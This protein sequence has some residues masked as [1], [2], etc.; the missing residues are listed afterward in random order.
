MSGPRGIA[1]ALDL[2]RMPALGQS[3][4][5]PPVPTDILEIMRIAAGSPEI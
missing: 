3:V 1:L 5:K 2:A 4:E